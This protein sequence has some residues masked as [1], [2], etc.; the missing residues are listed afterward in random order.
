MR[1]GTDHKE[2]GIGE[3]E[4]SGVGCTSNTRVPRAHAPDAVSGSIINKEVGQRCA[5]VSLMGK[6]RTLSDLPLR[7]SVI[8]GLF[9]Y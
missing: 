2:T 5:W 8:G 9:A 6:P 1:S 3:Y 7:L 4:G